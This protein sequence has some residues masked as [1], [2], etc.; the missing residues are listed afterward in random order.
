M[1][2]T[3]L[4][5]D[6]VLR[7]VIEMF[8]EKTRAAIGEFS[9]NTSL[10]ELGL[11]GGLEEQTLVIDFEDEFDVVFAMEDKFTTIGSIVDIVMK[12]DALQSSL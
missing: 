4:D 3:P 7:R 2:S 6:W 10:A 9:E 1:T 11:D 12:R 5:R 8:A